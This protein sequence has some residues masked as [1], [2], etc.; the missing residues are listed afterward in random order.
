M[1]SKLDT[2]TFYSV[3]GGLMVIVMAILS[4]YWSL[5]VTL[6]TKIEDVRLD[7]NTTKTTLTN[8]VTHTHINFRCEDSHEH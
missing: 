1:N 5:F 6:N 8:H 2:K 7:H 3:T 4:L